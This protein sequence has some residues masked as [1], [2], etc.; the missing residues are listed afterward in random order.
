M[1]PYPEHQ[2]NAAASVDHRNDLF[3]C[4][5]LLRVRLAGGEYRLPQLRRESFVRVAEAEEA[6]LL[7]K[8]HEVSPVRTYASRPS[9][10]LR[11]LLGLLYVIRERETEKSQ[12]HIERQC[13]SP[14]SCQ[15]S[16]VGLPELG[17]IV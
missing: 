11:K 14:R 16:S 5:G 13:E 2:K 10:P 9:D 1:G 17:G 15:Y 3:F 7:C 4:H 8:L 12:I 6:A